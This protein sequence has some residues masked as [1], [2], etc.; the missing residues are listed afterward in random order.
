MIFPPPSELNHEP[1][2]DL[3]PGLLITQKS[4]IVL[5]TK[6]VK[7]LAQLLAEVT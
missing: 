2:K 3:G 1:V 7:I 6:F 4:G 5:C